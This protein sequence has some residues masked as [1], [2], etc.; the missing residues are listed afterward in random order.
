MV[1][2]PLKYI[3]ATTRSTDLEFKETSPHYIFWNSSVQWPITKDFS[4]VICWK[5]L[6]RSIIM[7]TNVSHVNEGTG[8]PWYIFI[9]RS[10]FSP[11]LSFSLLAI[12]LCKH[13]P[14]LFD[15]T[16][17]KRFAYICY[18]VAALMHTHIHIM[19]YGKR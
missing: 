14:V 12:E 19:T 1:C 17:K 7:H 9:F 5:H 11:L 6:D 3:Q 2:E 18:R 16:E 8:F 15:Y 10:L 4:H 13:V